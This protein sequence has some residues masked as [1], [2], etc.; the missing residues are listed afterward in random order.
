[1][2]TK[3]IADG[4]AEN[5]KTLLIH[6]GLYSIPFIVFAVLIWSYNIVIVAILLSISHL[7]IDGTKLVL[8]KLIGGNAWYIEAENKGSLYVIDQLLH[9]ISIMVIVILYQFGNYVIN[10]SVLALESS[11]YMP[12]IKSIAVFLLVLKPVNITFMKLLMHLKPEDTYTESEGDAM[13]DGS[14]DSDSESRKPNPRVGRIIGNMERLLVV[15]F[16]MLSQFTAIG[17]VFTAKSIA[18]YDKISK[19]KAFAEYYLLGTLFSLLSTL[20]IYYTIMG[21]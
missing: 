11:V 15:I 8:N 12:V 20:V 1:M 2:Q 7:L 3:G 14:K 6:G 16:L 10:A 21:Y 4:K 9:L 19:N 17:L 13:E 18:R 5:V